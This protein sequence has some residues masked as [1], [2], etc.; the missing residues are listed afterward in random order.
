L[1]T[2]VIASTNTTM[3]LND[4]QI[5]E[6]YELLKHQDT[7]AVT[8]RIGSLK[9]RHSTNEIYKTKSDVDILADFDQIE[10]GV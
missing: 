6:I 7:I 4:D 5:L 1:L 9:M 3:K 8:L 2:N 10:T